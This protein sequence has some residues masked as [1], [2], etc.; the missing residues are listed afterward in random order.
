[1]R[2]S[3]RASATGRPRGVEAKIADVEHADYVDIY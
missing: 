2:S 3:P 1:M